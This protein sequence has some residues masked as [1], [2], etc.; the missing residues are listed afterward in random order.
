MSSAEVAA[1]NLKGLQPEDVKILLALERSM[2]TFESVPLHY[3]TKNSGLHADEVQFRLKRL[4]EK[5]FVVR[6]ASGYSLVMAGLDALALQGFVKRGLISGMGPSLGVGKEA[7]VFQAISDNGEIYAIKF[8]RLGRTSFRAARRKRGYSSPLFQHRWLVMNVEA[9]KREY[10]AIKVLLPIGVAVPE[11]LARERHALLMRHIDGTRLS[12]YRE[13]DEPGSV[14]EE[15]LRNV[16]QSFLQGGFVNADLSEY[17]ILFD[18]RKIWLIDW[19]QAV[20]KTHPN[21]ELLLERDLVNLI[22]FFKRR[23]GVECNP[24]VASLYV[25]GMSERL[26]VIRS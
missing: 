8:Y 10:E 5:E 24:S 9:A 25:K 26:E 20:R 12:E 4:N 18:G 23:F 15:I 2:F 22:R 13:L 17:N 3:L 1:R 21:S 16:R 6:N 14:L 7:D 11:V 19:P